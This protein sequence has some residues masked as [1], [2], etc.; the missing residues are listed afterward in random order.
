MKKIEFLDSPD[1]PSSSLPFSP[2]VSFGDLLFVSGQASVDHEG[3]IVK[4]S[5]EGEMRR[6][7]ENLKMILAASGSSLSRVLHLRAYVDDKND[8]A[9]FNRIYKEYFNDSQPARTTI[10]NCFQGMLKFEV[11]CIAARLA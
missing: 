2:A 8:L 5:F 6:S 9:E 7:M 10:T 11:D 4:D 1:L 3:S